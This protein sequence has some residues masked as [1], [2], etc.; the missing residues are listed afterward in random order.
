MKQPTPL[1]LAFS[2]GAAALISHAAPASADDRVAAANGPSAEP[3]TITKPA[4]VERQH[5]VNG[6]PMGFLFGSYGV[7]YEYLSGGNGLLVEGGFA[8]SGGD[9]ASATS[10]GGAVGYRWHWRGRQNSGFLGVNAGFY[11]GTA[12]ASSGDGSEMTDLTIRSLQLVMN[13]GKRWQFDN[14]LNITARIGGGKAKRW[15]STDSTDP[16]AQQAVEDVQDLLDFIPIALDGELSL[17]YSF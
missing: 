4:P 6:N 16:D 5:S 17:G 15:V 1:L 10:Y 8:H 13:I 3:I 2:F 12:T 14:G 7:T 11:A 9:S